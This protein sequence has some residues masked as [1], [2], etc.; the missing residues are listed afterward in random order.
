MNAIGLLWILLNVSFSADLFIFSAA[1][2]IAK[3]KKK[4]KK[5]MFQV[6]NWGG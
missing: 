2:V 4:N 1:I 6:D 5:Y 3:I